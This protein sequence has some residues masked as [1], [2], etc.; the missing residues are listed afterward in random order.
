MEAA[1]GLCIEDACAMEGIGKVLLL[2]LAGCGY[3]QGRCAGCQQIHNSRITTAADYPTNGWQQCLQV[4]GMQHG[5]PANMWRYVCRRN[6]VGPALC[7]N[8][9]AL[10]GAGLLP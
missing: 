8:D 9:L 10:P 1:L 5:M 3:E 6:S 4:G 7:K 2:C